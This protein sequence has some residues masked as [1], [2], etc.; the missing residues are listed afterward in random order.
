MATLHE[1]QQRIETALQDV[2]TLPARSWPGWALY[3]LEALDAYAQAHGENPAPILGAI[4]DD[5]DTRLA[6]GRW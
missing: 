2:T 6:L 1:V 3:F 5:I 4:R